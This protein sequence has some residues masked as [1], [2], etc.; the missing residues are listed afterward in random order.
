MPGLISPNDAITVRYDD[1]TAAIAKTVK[2]LLDDLSPVVELRLEGLEYQGST[3][4]DWAYLVMDMESRSE[5]GPD[6]YGE[7]TLS[8]EV[9]SRPRATDIYRHQEVMEKIR[10]GLQNLTLAVYGK[11]SGAPSTLRGNIQF[12]EVALEIVGAAEGLLIGTV[13]AAWRQRG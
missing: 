3:S 11:A 8:L 5:R 12:R 10:G 2:D 4:L 13:T 6:A 7:G 9:Y 1:T